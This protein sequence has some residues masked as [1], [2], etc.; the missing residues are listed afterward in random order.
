MSLG[1]LVAGG[2]SVR[3]PPYVGWSC[4]LPSKKKERGLTRLRAKGTHLVAH[5]LAC[6]YPSAPA[7]IPKQ[8]I[9]HLTNH[10]R[11]C[12]PALQCLRGYTR[13]TPPTYIFFLNK[14]PL[15]VYQKPSFLCVAPGQINISIPW[16]SGGG[17]EFTFLSAFLPHVIPWSLFISFQHSCPRSQHPLNTYLEEN[18]IERSRYLNQ[19][20]WLSAPI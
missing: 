7:P 11:W 5:D 19:S 8:Q 16:G 9:P 4:F 15:I 17:A 14:E 6:H 13:V 12:S 2:N 1:H 18:V 10:G 3:F 20:D